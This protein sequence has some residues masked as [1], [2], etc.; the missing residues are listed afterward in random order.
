[1]IKDFIKGQKLHEIKEEVNK[2][3]KYYMDI[4]DAVCEIKKV[5]ACEDI[6][7]EHD[8]HYVINGRIMVRIMVYILILMK[9]KFF[10]FNYRVR[11]V[12]LVLSI[13]FL[14]MIEIYFGLNFDNAQLCVV[15]FCFGY[16]L[17]KRRPPQ[18]YAEINDSI[19]G[20]KKWMKY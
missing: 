5:T 15:M 18:V 9:W 1:M 17:G 6:F 8:I 20:L 7:W 14:V 10:Y 19:F 11:N 16:Y 13:L 3:T 2:L 12:N 4:M